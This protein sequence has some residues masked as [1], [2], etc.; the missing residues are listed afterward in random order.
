MVLHPQR[1]APETA[2][3]LH[4]GAQLLDLRLALVGRLARPSLGVEAPEAAVV[5]ELA[6][7]VASAQLRVVGNE[8]LVVFDPAVAVHALQNEV[9]CRMR[10]RAWIRIIELVRMN[11]ILLRRFPSVNLLHMPKPHIL[12]TNC[13][14]LV[15]VR[16]VPFTNIL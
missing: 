6:T 3:E 12:L 16:I 15:F 1:R 14:I 10:Y 13:V 9:L 5:A 2:S 4:G 7:R 11:S 8:L